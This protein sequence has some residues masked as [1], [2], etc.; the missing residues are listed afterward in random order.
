MSWRG[1]TRAHFDR[2]SPP[3][4]GNFSRDGVSQLTG[5][6]VSGM[7]HASHDVEYDVAG[8]AAS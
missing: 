3:V 1:A 5:L 7:A 4:L 8:V 6:H 2:S